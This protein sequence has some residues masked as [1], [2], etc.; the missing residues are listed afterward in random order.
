MGYGQK[1]PFWYDEFYLPDK[2]IM[3]PYFSTNFIFNP[4]KTKFCGMKK[5]YTRTQKVMRRDQKVGIRIFAYFFRSGHGIHQ[6]LLETCM[7]LMETC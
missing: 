1:L 3:V 6:N 5:L 2:D 7:F 4:Y